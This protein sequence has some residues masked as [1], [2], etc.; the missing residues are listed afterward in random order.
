MI[1]NTAENNEEQ[2]KTEPSENSSIQN[3]EFIKNLPLDEDDSELK[4]LS[5]QFINRVVQ[6]IASTQSVSFSGPVPPPEQL[7]KY[8]QA[9]QNG[10]E[11]V[12]Q[13]AEKEQNHRHTLD[14][15]DQELSEQLVKTDNE[16]K[17]RDALLR[18]RGQIFAFFLALFCICTSV[19]LAFY[20]H[21]TVAGI[22]G[23]TTV[24]GLAGIFITNKVIESQKTDNNQEKNNSD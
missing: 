13:L 17:I 5:P 4:G 15:R 18:S 12:F 20:E 16:I 2:S 21:G 3:N 1:S 11:R 10:A 7:A 14:K 6:I 22:I 9:F 23:G 19:L 8:N 24:I